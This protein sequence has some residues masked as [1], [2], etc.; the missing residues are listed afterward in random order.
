M[1]QSI[2]RELSIPRPQEKVWRALTD[3]S[4][5]ALW[6]YPNDFEPIVGHQFT[7]QV[8]SNPK[9]GFVGLVVRCE[10][11]ECEPPRRLFSEQSSKPD[12]LSNH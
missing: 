9:V 10:V 4:T 2:R 11:L 3:A 12:T 1:S 8:P 5:L 6:M 7:F